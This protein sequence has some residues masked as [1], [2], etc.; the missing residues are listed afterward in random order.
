[1]KIRFLA[2]DS[3]RGI[4]AISVVLFHLSVLDSIS[5][6]N[7]FRYSYL[8]VDF[9]FV[10]SGFVITHS[11][12]TRS[13]CPS[14]SKYFWSRF[15][16][17][18]P[19]HFFMLGVFLFFEILKYLAF[20]YGFKFNN[21]P[22]TGY[23]SLAEF[24]PNLLLIQ[25]WSSSFQALSFNYTSWSISV[26]FYMYFIFYVLFVICMQRRLMFTPIICF[27]LGFMVF[28]DISFFTDK[29][30]DG[31]FAF[32]SGSSIYSL[33]YICSYS[34]YSVK[35]LLIDLAEIIVVFSIFILL[36]SGW[37][38]ENKV[39]SIAIFSVTVFIFSFELGVVSR[40]LKNKLFIFLG[41]LSYSIYLTHSAVIFCSL[42]AFM[43]IDKFFKTSFIVVYDSKNSSH[44]TRYY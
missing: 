9:F 35:G 2:L 44:L 1:M 20:N 8:F 39:A 11:L 37:L 6:I 15:K 29:A 33:Y 4:C 31:L 22:F 12:F 14:F 10:L 36:N 28:H 40:F 27:L 7:F 38:H 3:F 43:V 13:I 21:P 25:A 26:E 19:L 24:I 17:I 16:R 5:E 18:Y 41:E 23:S 32:F 30:R 42:S 34:K